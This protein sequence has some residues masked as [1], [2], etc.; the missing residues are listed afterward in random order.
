VAAEEGLKVVVGLTV[1]YL[2]SFAGLFFAWYHYR[3]RQR[4]GQAPREPPGGRAP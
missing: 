4:L 3:K 1:S 2:A